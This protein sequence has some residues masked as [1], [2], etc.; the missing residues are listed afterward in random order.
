MFCSASAECVCVL[1]YICAAWFSLLFSVQLTKLWFLCWRFTLYKGFIIIISY[2]VF[3]FLIHFL[4]VFSLPSRPDMTFAADWALKKQWSIYQS[5]K[6]GVAA[7]VVFS[8]INISHYLFQFFFD[9]TAIWCALC[10]TS[11]FCRGPC[12]KG[13]WFPTSWLRWKTSP[14]KRSGRW[15]RSRGPRARV[16][17]QREAHRPSRWKKVRRVLSCSVNQTFRLTWGQD[18]ACKLGCW[19]PR[20]SLVQLQFQRVETITDQSFHSRRHCHLRGVK[21]WRVSLVAEIPAGH[22]CKFSFKGSKPLRTNLS[23]QGSV[24]FP[25]HRWDTLHIANV[26]RNIDSPSVSSLRHDALTSIVTRTAK[27]QCIWVSCM[28]GARVESTVCQAPA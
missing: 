26:Q 6:C 12:R 5:P 14:A 15:S 16:R 2:F 4:L 18:L 17:S 20:G 11:G 27:F 13:W 9:L 24:P 19:N 3:S 21:T 28:G 25:K 23:A 1:Y 22:W 8:I 7:V 10:V